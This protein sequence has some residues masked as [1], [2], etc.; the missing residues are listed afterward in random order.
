MDSPSR[1]ICERHKTV[2]VRWDGYIRFKISERAVIGRGREVVVLEVLA[3]D[4][5]RIHHLVTAQIDVKCRSLCWP[6]RQQWSR[7]H[8]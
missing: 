2:A 1:R 5:D 8:R 4:E 3:F 6:S 7:R